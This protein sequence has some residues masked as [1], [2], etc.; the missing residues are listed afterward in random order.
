MPAIISSNGDQ[1]WYQNGKRHREND[2]PAVIFSNGDRQW[3]QNGV[4]YR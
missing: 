2:N 1:E 4:K 3:Y